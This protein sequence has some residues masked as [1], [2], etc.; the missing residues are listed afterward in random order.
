M[1]FDEQKSSSI[2]WYGY[3]RATSQKDWAA[4]RS[5][6]WKQVLDLNGEISREEF[7]VVIVDRTAMAVFDDSPQ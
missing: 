5:L 2:A 1:T 6:R 3:A 4:M 7:A